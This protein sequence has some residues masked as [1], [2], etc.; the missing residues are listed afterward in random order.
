MIWSQLIKKVCMAGVYVHVTVPCTHDC[1]YGMAAL[2]PRHCTAPRHSALHC[3][4][5][6]C[7][8]LHRA[9]ALR[10]CTAAPCRA[11]ADIGIARAMMEALGAELLGQVLCYLPPEDLRSSRQAARIFDQA[12]REHPEFFRTISLG[13][14]N[15]GGARGGP[16]WARFPRLRRLSLF[17]WGRMHGEALCALF[18]RGG[19]GLSSLRK[20]D[21]YLER[22][23]DEKLWVSILKHAP[24]VTSVKLMWSLE[25]HSQHACLAVAATIGSLV[26]QLSQ[27]DDSTPQ[28]GAQLAG[29]IARTMPNLR[30]LKL[31]G[32]AGGRN[33]VEAL[34]SAWEA[35]PCSRLTTLAFEARPSVPWR[36]CE[37]AH[38]PQLRRLHGIRLP[39]EGAVA[40]ARGLP[41]LEALDAA[42]EGQR[43]GA[44]QAVFGRVR[45]A[46][47]ADCCESFTA[48]ARISSLLPSLERLTLWE[49]NESITTDLADATRLTHLVL[50]SD[51]G[52]D[53]DTLQP[54]AWA[55]LF[56]MSRLRHLA[57]DVL[58]AELPQLARLPASLMRLIHSMYHTVLMRRVRWTGFPTTWMTRPMCA[59]CR[60]RLGASA[61][62][63]L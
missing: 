17:V 12:S 26:P 41:S 15:A 11:H 40:L 51:S 61:A 45:Q 22:D 55:A 49:N 8:A 28:P 56:T 23:V 50:G 31:R 5:L 54:R 9:T 27:F 2:T 34:T 46:R 14:R 35:L 6:H 3:T 25:E 48:H 58:P 62:C 37:T 59:G 38:W 42:P 36:V 43:A 16:N 57:L 63:A 32:L 44:G 19:A 39:G 18:A 33:N 1:G 20:V 7:T 52:T 21:A 4:A 13:C 30:S 24:G 60:R 29:V 10:H 47:L 53:F